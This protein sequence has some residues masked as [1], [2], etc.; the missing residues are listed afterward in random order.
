MTQRISPN[1]TLNE[2]YFI[3]CNK[4]S[5]ATICKNCGGEK[6]FHTIGDGIKCTKV[7][8]TTQPNITLINK[9]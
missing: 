6:M 4:T 3:K 8:I 7:I 9:N 1:N 5:S 2:C